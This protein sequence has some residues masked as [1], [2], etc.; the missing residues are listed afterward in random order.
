MVVLNL[1]HEGAVMHEKIML[2]H[3]SDRCWLKNRDHPKTDM[4]NRTE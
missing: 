4:S 2:R 3:T 1:F